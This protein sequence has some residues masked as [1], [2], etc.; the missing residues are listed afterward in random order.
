MTYRIAPLTFLIA[1]AVGGCGALDPSAGTEVTEKQAAFQQ[2]VEGAVRAILRDPDSAKFSE[3]KAYPDAGVACG[4]VN[5]KNAFGGFVGDENFAYA[6][7]RAALA[8]S[9]PDTWGIYSNACAVAMNGD[10][11]LRL[12]DAKRTLAAS[13]APLDERREQEDDIDR[14]IAALKNG[15]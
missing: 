5:A 14:Q 8:S 3:V 4:K 12:Q 6:D 9:N 11:L 1:F 2:T 7:G 13:G 10:A 15:N